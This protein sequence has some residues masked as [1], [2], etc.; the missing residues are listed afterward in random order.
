MVIVVG[1]QLCNGYR[2][3]PDVERDR[4]ILESA[5]IAANNGFLPPRMCGV[6]RGAL[7]DTYDMRLREYATMRL[8]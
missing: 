2:L 3:K 5:S 6:L 7:V 4:C 1:A 8:T